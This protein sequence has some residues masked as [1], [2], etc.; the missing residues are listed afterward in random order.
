MI[1]EYLSVK[2]KNPLGPKGEEKNTRAKTQNR[3]HGIASWN[4]AQ[5]FY[6]KMFYEFF[7]EDK[8]DFIIIF[9]TL[10]WQNLY[11]TNEQ[12]FIRFTHFCRIFY[13]FL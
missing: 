6:S 5:W 3:Y 7:I 2:C 1:P 8:M 10:V 11:E 9:K 4:Q 13:S 12:N